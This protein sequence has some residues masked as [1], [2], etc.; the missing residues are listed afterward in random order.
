[1]PSYSNLMTSTKSA[2][3]PSSKA[4]LLW[5][6]VASSDDGDLDTSTLAQEEEEENQEEKQEEEADAYATKVATLTVQELMP[7][8]LVDV[9]SGKDMWHNHGIPRLGL[10]AMRMTDGPCGARGPQ[11]QAHVA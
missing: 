3:T 6:N 1:M 10:P 11:F 9:I 4:N 2:P 8:E 7:S 5:D